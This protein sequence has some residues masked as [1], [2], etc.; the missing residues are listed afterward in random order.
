MHSNII[1]LSVHLNHAIIGTTSDHT[2]FILFEVSWLARFYSLPVVSCKMEVYLKHDDVIKWKHFP[3]YWPFVI[4]HRWIPRTK[5][6]EAELWYSF[7]NRLSKQSRGWW[8]E[9]PL[10]PFWLHCNG[11]GI[12]LVMTEGLG[13]PPCTWY[14]CHWTIVS[15]DLCRRHAR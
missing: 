6:S 11:L 13:N 9:T 10:R 4:G 1:T 15:H 2:L 14:R 12:Y 5:A 8:F 7:Y 3:R